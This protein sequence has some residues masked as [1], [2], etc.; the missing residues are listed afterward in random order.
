MKKHKIM[1]QISCRQHTYT[2]KFSY[3][4]ITKTEIK[5]YIEIFSNNCMFVHHK[6]KE[7]VEGIF[8]KL[9][10]NKKNHQ[11]MCHEFLSYDNASLHKE[12]GY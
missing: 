5:G 9:G 11:R 4:P 6:K 10:I 1:I 7:T 3:N 8:T 2:L 12:S